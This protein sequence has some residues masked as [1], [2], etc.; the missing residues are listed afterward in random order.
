MH[1]LTGDRLLEAWDRGFHESDLVRP[2]T[3]LQVSSPERSLESIAELSLA[4]RDLDLWRLRRMTFGDW[5]RATLPC[6]GCSAQIEFTLAISSV[7][8]PLEQLRIAAPAERHWEGWQIAMRPAT[9]VD[10]EAALEMPDPDAAKE[11]L[12]ERCS[13]LTAPPGGVASWEN[14]PETLRAVAQESFDAVHEG[15]EFLC[16]T[17]C[18]QCGATEMADLDIGRFLWFEVRNAAKRLLRDVHELA[19]AYGWSEAAILAMTT[20]RR[21]GYLAM[22]RA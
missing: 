1:A 8:E 14:A 4:E 12:L 11:R 20:Q 17:I 10:L 22:V 5:L 3:L 13:L 15:A 9:T 18:P 7:I 21:Q 16:E 19:C 6:A 2:L